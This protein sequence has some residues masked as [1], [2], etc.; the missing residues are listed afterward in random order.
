MKYIPIILFAVF[1][2]LSAQAKTL[3]I[4]IDL[5]GSNP[6]LSHSNFAYIASQY[7][8]A[9]INKLKSGDIVQVKTFGS[10][11]DALNLLNPT[12]EISRRMNTKKVAGAVSKYIQSLPEQKDIDQ[13]ST[14]LLAWLEFTSGFNCADNGHI[15]VIT[16]AIESSSYVNG[17]LFVQGKQKL[18][19]PDVDLSG[20]A[21]TFYGLG[22]GW[23]VQYVKTIRNEWTH[24]AKE[25]G[26]TFTAVIP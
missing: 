14:N 15:L 22:A 1:T 10:R 3:T 24:W 7:V 18:P 12:F 4:G 26:A 11:A 20:C 23:Q 13:S 21:L 9:E 25:A 6:L 5:S 17:N 16:D 19:K 2:T 8:A